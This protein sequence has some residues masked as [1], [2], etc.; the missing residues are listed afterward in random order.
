MKLNRKVNGDGSVIDVLLDDEQDLGDI[1]SRLSE[2]E[3]RG[4]APGYGP[5]TE[6][7]K[8]ARVAQLEMRDRRW[9]EEQF[10]N[11]LRLGREGLDERAQAVGVDAAGGYITPASFAASFT[12]SLKAHDEIFEASTLIETDR[13]TGCSFPID[14]DTA[15]VATIVAESGTSLLSSPVVF[16]QIAFGRAPMWR[17]GHIICSNE[18]VTDSR[19]NLAG[20]LARNFGKR[21]ARGVGAS[22]ITKLLTD[23]DVAVTSAAPTALTGDELLDL[24]SAVDSDYQMRGSFLMRSATLTMLRK[25][26]SSSG[27]DYLLPIG[28]DANGRKTLFDFPVYESPSMPAATAGLKAIAFGDLSRF[29]RRQVR[30]S[31]T[32]RSY[33]E[34]YA[35]ADQTAFEGFLRVDSALSKAA[36]APMPIRLLAMHS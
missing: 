35:T 32:V 28:R 6:A 29:I 24:V 2:A 31:L 1:A 14:D 16:D 25:I 17:T 20:L 19:F 30:N 12:E 36:N 22:F 11:F 23:A 5:L 4:L 18:L 7:E 27:G 26:K 34:R 33:T 9:Q 15:A 10:R 21:F 13:G 3:E 8:R